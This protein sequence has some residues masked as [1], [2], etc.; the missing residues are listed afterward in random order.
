MK[1]TPHGQDSI[2]RGYRLI[3]VVS[4]SR[5][6]NPGSARQFIGWGCRTTV[7]VIFEGYRVE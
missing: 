2:V 7:M 3:Y 1:E 6:N 4:A 5:N